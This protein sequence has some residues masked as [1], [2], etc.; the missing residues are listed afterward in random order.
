MAT[1]QRLA[2]AKPV[3]AITYWIAAGTMVSIAR[4]GSCTGSLASTTTAGQPSA[5]GT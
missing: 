3:L 2:S 4:P 5:A 1:Q